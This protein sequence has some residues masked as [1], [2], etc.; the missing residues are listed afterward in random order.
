MLS[1][2][3]Y[4]CRACTVILFIYDFFNMTRQTAS[5][6]AGRQ[7]GRQAQVGGLRGVPRARVKLGA[8]RVE[9]FVWHH[10][11]H[12]RMIAVLLHCTAKCFIASP[13]TTTTTTCGWPWVSVCVSPSVCVC[14]ACA[15]LCGLLEFRYI[16]LWLNTH[17]LC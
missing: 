16:L 10:M 9:G 11:L 2:R 1:L 14:V 17:S 13:A 3:I 6:Q 8:Q 7:A 12:C 5:R 4:L 15:L